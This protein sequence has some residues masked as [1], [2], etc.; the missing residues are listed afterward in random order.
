MNKEPY[1]EVN[2]K[3]TSYDLLHVRPVKQHGLDVALLD[4]REEIALLFVV[5]GQSDDVPHVVR[6]FY[7]LIGGVVG[8]CDVFRHVHRL[9]GRHSRERDEGCRNL[10]KIK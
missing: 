2:N 7:L 5:E 1:D 9:D 8:R 3:P 4:V 6:Q 10:E